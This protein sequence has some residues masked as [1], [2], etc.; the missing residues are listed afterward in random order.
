MNLEKLQ[1]NLNVNFTDINL[2][3]SALT[4]KSFFINKKFRN[5]PINPRGIL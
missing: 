5:S 2:L 3:V 4:H 1:S